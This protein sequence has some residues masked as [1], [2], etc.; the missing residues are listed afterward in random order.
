METDNHHWTCGSCGHEGDG[1][2]NVEWYE[3][4]KVCPGRVI[5]PGSVDPS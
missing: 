2:D 3:H 5:P 1:P 4:T